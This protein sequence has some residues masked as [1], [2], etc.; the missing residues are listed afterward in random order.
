M[1]VIPSNAISCLS[2]WN[3]VY[4]QLVAVV[5]SDS[6]IPDSLSKT[7]QG[8]TESTTVSFMTVGSSK[9]ECERFSLI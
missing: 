7:T 9:Y 5:V 1:F 6:L 4:C 3:N 8:H 2:I